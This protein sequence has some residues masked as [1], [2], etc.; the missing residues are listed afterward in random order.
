MITRWVMQQRSRRGFVLATVLIFI[1]VV[2]I[3]GGAF[4]NLAASEGLHASQSAL[5]VKALYLAEAGC[6]WGRAWLSAQ[7]TP[8]EQVTPITFGDRGLGDGS[9]RVT[10]N[11]DPG[12]PSNFIKRYTIVGEGR[13]RSEDGMAVRASKSVTMVVRLESFARYAYLTNN[14]R[15]ADNRTTMWFVSADRINGP[16]HSN[17]QIHISGSP[18]FE[19]LVTSTASS[20]DFYNGGPPLDNPN[21]VEGYKLN[22]AERDFREVANL[23][24]LEDAARAGGLRLRVQ[25]AEIRFNADGTMTYRTES[26][27]KW[28]SWTTSALPGNGVIYVE[29]D[30]IV[31]G[32]LR[33]QVTLATQQGKSIQIPSDLCY[34]G[35]PSDPACTDMLGLVAGQSINVT[36]SSPA[37]AN[38]TIHASMIALGTHF[39]VD[40][41]DSIPVMGTLTVYGSI[42]QKNR[43]PVATFDPRTGRIISG[44]A[45]N[46]W[47][48]NRLRDRTPPYFPTTGRYEVVS[49]AESATNIGD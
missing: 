31:Y 19:G 49:W 39:T 40:D 43:G 11:P 28:S 24:Q 33:G 42:V 25:T 32:T 23:R 38:L 27:N 48:D 17:S 41:Y 14:E 21:F 46:Y 44:Y 36:K 4:L 16:L 15:S 22:A 7:A 1:V 20:F 5:P 35:D 8:P 34:S 10:I 2:T 47:Y 30:A 6:Q 37:G 18:T 26:G 13:V 29:G 12:N 45:K 3:A 9:Y